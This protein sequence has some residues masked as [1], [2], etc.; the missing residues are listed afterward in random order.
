MYHDYDLLN[1]D[2]INKYHVKLPEKV[3]N[4]VFFKNDGKLKIL[5]TTLVD[6][7]IKNV[8]DI[9]IDIISKEVKEDP[10]KWTKIKPLIKK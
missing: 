6:N 10:I 1:K 3:R 2:L 9:N 5:S 7:F 4:E 8:S